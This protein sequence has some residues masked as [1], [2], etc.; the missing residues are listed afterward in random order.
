MAL[1]VAN[2]LKTEPECALYCS[3]QYAVSMT[4]FRPSYQIRTGRLAPVDLGLSP[5]QT[6][7]YKVEKECAD[8]ASHLA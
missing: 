2:G 1:A 3:P 5:N 4:R 8:G 6:F 7:L